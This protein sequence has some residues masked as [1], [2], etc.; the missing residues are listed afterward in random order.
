MSDGIDI[1]TQKTQALHHIATELESQSKRPTKLA[2]TTGN[3]MIDQFQ[4][5][6]FGVAFAFLFTFCVGMPDK[7]DFQ[8]DDTRL[9]SRLL[10]HPIW[11]SIMAR[12]VEGQFIR[13]WHFGYV[14]WN[15]ALKATLN[16]SKSLLSY[17]YV[18]E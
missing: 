11:D 15:C 18:M 9:R 14:S 8:E 10:E 7:P 4:P 13:D 17:D 16:L 5:W 12:R 6:Y 2:A 1:V 3:S